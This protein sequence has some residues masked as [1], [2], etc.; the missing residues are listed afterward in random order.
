MTAPAQA[1]GGTAPVA[2]TPAATPVPTNPEEEVEYPHDTT[3]IGMPGDTVEDVNASFAQP[4]AIFPNFRIP[5]FT[6]YERFKRTVD[7]RYN[8]RFGFNYQQLYQYS[9]ATVPNATYNT[10][11]SG[12]AAIEALWTPYYRNGDFEGTFVVRL[13]WRDPIGDSAAGSTFGIPQLGSLWSN[14]EFTTWNG[15]L[16]VEDLF[17]EQWMTRRLRLRIGNQIPT[18]V[19]NFSR[20]KD[21]RVS[22]T[23]SPFAFHD[24]IPYPTFGLGMSARWLPI[25]GSELYVDGV[26][27]D[28]NGDPNGEGLNWATFGRKQYF[29]GT[30][31]GYRWRRPNGEFDHLHLDL[32][33]ADKRSTRSPNASPNKAGGGFRVYGEKQF[34]KIVAIGGYTYNTAQGGGISTTFSQQVV[35]AGGAFL[36]PVKIRGEIGAGFMWSRP[37]DNI[38]PGLSQRDQQGFET[39][40]RLLLTPNMTVTPGVQFIFNPSF[41][42]VEDHMVVP[43]IKFRLVF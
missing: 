33:Y 22:F 1:T 2:A 19:F 21:A 10:A 34:G 3:E 17:W 26:L 41:N 37:I 35:T 29:Y 7:E 14:Y 15:A 8:L 23:A 16:K 12:W 24:T 25:K 6:A 36:N 30:E 28:M 18:A 20:F 27:N 5:G 39:Y 11:N 43:S 40:W 31:I 9:T 38:L 13:G 42:P 4:G 32:F